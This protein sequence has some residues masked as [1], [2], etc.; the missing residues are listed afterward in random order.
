[1]LSTIDNFESSLLRTGEKDASFSA[2]S[3]DLAGAARGFGFRN[4]SQIP[5]D[6]HLIERE[7]L[8]GCE[9]DAP[10][11]RAGARSPGLGSPSTINLSNSYHNRS[12]SGADH[13]QLTLNLKRIGIYH[14]EQPGIIKANQNNNNDAIQSMDRSSVYSNNPTGGTFDAGKAGKGKRLNLLNSSVDYFLTQKQMA[15]TR[16]SQ[17][18]RSPGSGFPCQDIKIKQQSLDFN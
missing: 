10:P 12:V 3:P 8:E 13:Q 15:R 4:R 5:V 7:D 9:G 1:M 16:S 14:Q 2:A 6:D 11:Q 18:K 17:G